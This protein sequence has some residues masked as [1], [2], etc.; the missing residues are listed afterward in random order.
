MDKKLTSDHKL[1]SQDTKLES[2]KC[3]SNVTK[4]LWQWSWQGS[5]NRRW[6][7]RSMSWEP[8]A[9][10]VPSVTVM[11]SGRK[12]LQK[13][14]SLVPTGASP[15]RHNFELDSELR[16]IRYLSMFAVPGSHETHRFAHVCTRPHRIY[17]RSSQVRQSPMSLPTCHGFIF[18]C[19][20]FLVFR[21]I[22]GWLQF[23][24]L[25]SV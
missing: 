11:P 10:Q 20:F 5:P 3:Q 21:K 23:H 24:R 4:L 6:R 18:Y 13:S 15:C 2:M 22:F 19:F 17:T 7:G 16:L 14:I 12:R 25:G 9:C 1:D 8:H